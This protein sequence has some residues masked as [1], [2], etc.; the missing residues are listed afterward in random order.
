MDRNTLI[1]LIILGVATI[2][3][4]SFFRKFLVLVIIV[5]AI[6]AGAWWYYYQ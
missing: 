3:G 5:V 4:I 6:A 2:I 1:G